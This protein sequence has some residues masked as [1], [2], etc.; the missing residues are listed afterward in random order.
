MGHCPSVFLGNVMTSRMVPGP[1]TIA[2]SRSNRG[3]AA[4]RRRPVAE[5][6]QQEA[7][8]LL[9]LLFGETQEPEYPFLSLGVAIRS[10]RMQLDA[11]AH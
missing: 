8:A 3:D 1:P 4:V 5:C 9:G 11:I 10:S 2:T 7:E 6:F